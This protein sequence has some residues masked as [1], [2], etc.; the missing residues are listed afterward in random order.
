V[1]QQED[2]SY[3][4]KST[5]SKRRISSV[6]SSAICKPWNVTHLKKGKVTNA[7]VTAI[8]EF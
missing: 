1:P 4:R 2:H 6:Y 3:A 5:D 8:G 7:S